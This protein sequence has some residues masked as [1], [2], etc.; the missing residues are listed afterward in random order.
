M[1]LNR[2]ITPQ[3]ATA[4][5]IR[6]P[7][8]AVDEVITI[9]NA[10]GLK[11][12]LEFA[13]D[14][15]TTEKSGNDLVFTFPEGGQVIVSDFFAQLEG[16]N[17][18]TFVIEGQELPGDAFL[19]AFNAEL[20][21]AAGPGAGG[22]AGSGGVGDYTDDPGNLVDSVDRL[23][24]LDP[25]VF[26]RGTEPLPLTDVGIVDNGVTIT[27]IAP[28]GP[29]IGAGEG[30]VDETAL[31]SGS[32][33]DAA[34][35]TLT[36]DFTIT[37]PDGLATVIIGGETVI[38]GGALVNSTVTGD[39]GTLTITGYNPVT[40]VI[41]YSY[42]LTGNADHTAGD[43]TIFET[44]PITA[45]DTDGDLASDSLN[46]QILDDAPVIIGGQAEVDETNF[47]E[48]NTS[49][50]VT[51]LLVSDTG[52]NPADPWGDGVIE[53]QG[54]L[55]FSA[56]ADGVQSLVFDATI[57]TNGPALTSQG[58]QVLF[59]VSDDGK[60]LRGY[61]VAEGDDA[62]PNG[63]TVFTMTI[64]N[65]GKYTYTQERP[66]DHSVDGDALPGDPASTDHPHNDALQF[67]VGVVLTDTDTD[68]ATGNITVVVR[69]DGPRVYGSEE[70]IERADYAAASDAPHASVADDA[71]THSFNFTS[72]STL[73][74]LISASTDA[75]TGFVDIRMDGGTPYNGGANGLGGTYDGVQVGAADGPDRENELGYRDDKTSHEQEALV[76]KLNGVADHFEMD[77]SGALSGSEGS[78]ER[79]VV[80]FF[81]GDQLVGARTITS[82][83]AGSIEFTGLFDR[84]VVTATD[85][86]WLSTSDN[87]D[88]YIKN[89]SFHEADAASVDIHSG[90]LYFDYGADRPGSFELVFDGIA[91]GQQPEAESVEYRAAAPSD[92]AD[93]TDASIWTLDGRRVSIEPERDSEGNPIAGT[94]VGHIINDDGTDSGQVAFTLTVNT[95]TGEWTLAQRVPLDLPENGGKLGFSYT[96][97]DTDGDTASGSFT[98]TVNE[99]DRA[100][101]IDM[102][103]V[104]HVVDENGL[105]AGNDASLAAVE[106]AFRID[107]NGED[108]TSVSI[109]GVSF[110]VSNGV[111]TINDLLGKVFN[112]GM[113]GKDVTVDGYLGVPSHA[114]LEIIGVSGD[115][116]S[117]YSVQYRYT[118][119]DNVRHGQD[120]DDMKTGDVIPVSVTTTGADGH[121]QSASASLTVTIVDDTPTIDLAPA[122]GPVTE[123]QSIAG[124]WTHAMGA[125]NDL[126][127]SIKVVIG[128]NEY[129]INQNIYTS[130][131]ILRVNGDGEWTFAAKNNLDHDYKQELKFALRITDSDGD[132]K[133]TDTIT[134][135][136][137]D[138]E[139][140]ARAGTLTLTLDDDA[141]S[142]HAHPDGDLPFLIDTDKTSGSLSFTAGSDDFESFKFVDASGVQME[143][144]GAALT[145]AVE[146]GKLVGRYSNGDK[147]VILSLSGGNIDAGETGNVT[148]HAELIDPLLHASDSDL[149]TI[150][151]I[152][153][154]GTD[155]DGDYVDGSVTLK[156]TD[157]MPIAKMDAD[158]VSEDGKLIASG[159]VLSNDTAPGY[160]LS[161]DGN[162]VTHIAKGDGAAT[163]FSE[164]GSTEIQGEYGTLTIYADG[165]YSYSLNNDDPRVQHLNSKTDRLTE[166]F[167]YTVTDGDGDASTAPLVITIVGTDDGVSIKGLEGSEGELYEKYLPGGTEDGLG[168]LVTAE[169]EFTIDVKDGLGS[170]TMSYG[171]QTVDIAEGAVLDTPYGNLTITGFDAV[172]GKV[173]YTFELDR[174]APHT[175]PATDET[176]D[177]DITV[178]LTDRDNDSTS[179]TINIDIKDDAPTLTVSNGA[180]T[181]DFG[182][183]ALVHVGFGA[184]TH[185]GDGDMIA[186]GVQLQVNGGTPNFTGKGLGVTYDGKPVAGS[187]SPDRENELGYRD[188][189]TSGEQEG[190][191]FELDGVANRFNM[192]APNSFYTGGEG[193]RGQV[194][195]F[196]GNVQVASQAIPSDGKFT[197]TGVLFDRVVVQAVDNSDGTTS[198]DNS[199]F[200]IKGVDVGFVDSI[201][202]ASGTV[203]MD[204]GADGEATSGALTFGVGTTGIYTYDGHAVTVTPSADGKTLTG[205]YDGGKTAFTMSLDTTDG[206]WHFDQKVPLDLPGTTHKLGFNV[207]ITDAD[208]DTTPAATIEVTVNE[209]ERAPDIDT[210]LTPH[211]VHESGLNTADAAGSG[212]FPGGY[213]SASDPDGSPV[214]TEGTFRINANGESITS[215]GIAGETISDLSTLVGRT[216][217]IGANGQH[218]ASG[219]HATLAI[220][221]YD[222]STGVVSYTYTLTDNVQHS[223]NV[224]GV[225]FDNEK[226]GDVIPVSVTTG[227]GA[228]ASTATATITVTIVDDVPTAELNTFGSA[229]DS[230]TLN[231]GQHTKGQFNM[232]P[233]ADGVGQLL[234]NG[235]AFDAT[236]A[237]SDGYQSF[238]GDH[239]TLYVNADGEYRYDG[240]S[241]GNDSFTFTLVDGDGDRVADT[242]SLNVER[243]NTEPVLTMGD[244]VSVSEAALPDGSSPALS[245]T[246]TGTFTFDDKGEGL[247]SLTVAGQTIDLGAFSTSGH[248]QTVVDDATGKLVITGYNSATGEVSYEYTLKDNTLEGDNVQRTFEV[249]VTD[250]SGD[251][252]KANIVI[253]VTDDAP[254]AHDDF[255][256]FPQVNTTTNLVIVLDTSGSMAWDSGVDGK[257]RMELAQE[258]I[259][260][261][262]HAYDDMGH[263]N[264]KIV[265]FYSDAD[266]SKPWFE[267]ND[268]VAKATQY[269]TTDNKFV[270]GGGTDYDDATAATASALQTGMPNADRTVLYFFSDG[271]PDPISEALNATEEKAWVDALKGVDNLDIAYAIGIGSQ[272]STT[273]LL[274][275]G[276]ERNPTDP[277]N[278]DAHSTKVLTDLSQLESTLLNTVPIEGNLLN[279]DVKGADG[280]YIEKVSFTSEDGTVYTATWNT[281]TGKLVFTTD[282]GGDGTI[283]NSV[284]QP[285]SR[286]T[287]SLGADRGTVEFDFSDGD[288]RY[289]PGANPT[290]T[291]TFDYTIRDGDGDP[292]SAHL[293]LQ[294]KGAAVDA[295]DNFAFTKAALYSMDED[296]N[297]WWNSGHANNVKDAPTPTFEFN[298]STKSN[299][300][301]YVDNDSRF[302]NMKD[303]TVLLF[304]W[305]A[306][307][308]NDP[309]Q[310]QDNRDVDIVTL[311]VKN[312][313]TGQETEKVLFD[314]REGSPRNGQALYEFK[315]PGHEDDYQVRIYAKDTDGDF[316]STKNGLTVQISSLV[317][318]AAAPLIGNLITDAS[319]DDLAGM[320]AHVTEVNG[321][322]I[323]Q[324]GSYTE[325]THEQYGS[326]QVNMYGDYRYLAN[327]GTTGHDEAFVYKIATPT[328]QEDHATLNIH[329]GAAGDHTAQTTYSY[330]Y[331]DHN[332]ATDTSMV[333]IGGSGDDTIVGT[334]GDDIILGGLGNDTLGGSGGRD[335][336]DG[337]LGNDTIIIQDN[338]GDHRITDA[339]FKGLHG[340][341]GTDTLEI[342]GD[343]VVLDFN[344][345]ADGK[346]SGIE[347][348]DLGTDTGAQTVRLTAADLFDLAGT[349][350]ATAAGNK[351]V[352]ISGDNADKV[353]LVGSDWTHSTNAAG[354][355]VYSV[356][357][358]TETRDLIIDHTIQQQIINSGG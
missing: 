192:D 236:K 265:D 273:H 175:T 157:D 210:G 310:E 69:D 17:V 78:G 129:S 326:L 346:V 22:G 267:G 207:G 300:Q 125:D 277:D 323:A 355:D 254:T 178:T 353:E 166:T 100:P 91:S 142:R 96:I 199:D 288:F 38:S 271:A 26:E 152:K 27:N 289:V 34:G 13:P 121:A 84:V 143:G 117:G 282:L 136:I 158:W 174:N 41:T 302:E 60:T 215:V 272:V 72:G 32:A 306:L 79:G 145:W 335:Y 18:P 316:L 63:L 141:A 307:V 85:R 81:L 283:D 180:V 200:Y 11:L 159:N 350:E 301:V 246:T 93:I 296:D 337:G 275:V 113:N 171:G 245:E 170:L 220:T 70:F 168:S 331:D 48:G 231:V 260:K 314:G 305:K 255:A 49:G 333:Y 253:N 74:D 98:V 86:T 190:V 191:V 76:F 304:D 274:P 87:S 64:D 20:L 36:G 319:A 186:P 202:K 146:S 7:A 276:W 225:L 243:G 177:L 169:R 197:Y 179:A 239:G 259:A 124:T 224:G 348:I 53:T 264:I 252:A 188:D 108:L 249:K 194:L 19:T 218:V 287:F 266:A 4:G 40:G 138:G 292:S 295:K 219:G 9:Q 278:P 342:H 35:R 256:T 209:V 257:S 184:D 242:L 54:T 172:T 50:D 105:V 229:D 193:E 297:Q 187:D 261:L 208:G 251:E 185:P 340:G 309:T 101:D 45:T 140:P 153:V 119:K 334:A 320:T 357:V 356:T 240:T 230:A 102:P 290:G 134:V 28:G 150:T 123:G 44:F 97:T 339:D 155:I 217:N 241:V 30:I 164:N 313:R 162:R 352:H 90:M 198:S 110:S 286:V 279:N 111:E 315:N 118:L 212:L 148:V 322:P 176:F 291:P 345:I 132:T 66:L 83:T 12:A 298:L 43:D 73:A 6:L 358:G 33:P 284:V 317:L 144:A 327:E 270:P 106:G 82:S 122:A 311:Y 137:N 280:A 332:S 228:D 268:A 244:P 258:A 201:G 94:M 183:S 16:G 23:G 321:Q 235:V 203:D 216:F 165:S 233:G 206:E 149:V 325:I 161:A 130:K 318:L 247:Q 14:A 5:T 303:G 341:A 1:P 213:D 221:G 128:G 59:D 263:V 112:I 312:L 8:P 39:Y 238:A 42:E 222:A 95:A 328:G 116:T 57:E 181:D 196:L 52:D 151:G 131:G 139:G 336:I 21:P 77:A 329:I 156:V 115:A 269:L 68:T 80:Q 46:I 51:P 338:S 37:A 163:D 248:T 61:I 135:A 293:Y 62:D 133:L 160:D 2:T 349:S 234:V 205:T 89:V 31:A 285:G 126:G 120:L 92:G 324:D 308:N 262:M 343:N 299:T 189:K 294:L 3:Q 99:A 167:K 67:N 344:N 147:A 55:N 25:L 281:S 107:T 29:D 114:T 24:T 204:Y 227:T 58:A 47:R 56:G 330:A 237:G 103:P 71:L 211:V 232:V 127:S 75:N 173:T 10:A 65:T 354:Q 250:T 214:V 182:Q 154:R 347:H 104:A 109:A 223:I 226:T 351:A 88:F 195:F 15:A